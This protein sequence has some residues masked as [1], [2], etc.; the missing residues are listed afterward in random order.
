MSRD[1]ALTLSFFMTFF[2]HQNRHVIISQTKTRLFNHKFVFNFKTKIDFTLHRYGDDELCSVMSDNSNLAPSL[3]RM[4]NKRKNANA[5]LRSKDAKDDAQIKTT[6]IENARVVVLLL[7]T[8]NRS[9]YADRYL[10]H[11]RARGGR[12]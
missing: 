4:R 3:R 5:I 10:P 8:Q 7:F 9:R 12:S 11:F 6:A 2:E 1:C